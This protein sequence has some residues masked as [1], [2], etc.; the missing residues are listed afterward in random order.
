MIIY[1]LGDGICFPN[2]L[3]IEFD[4]EQTNMTLDTR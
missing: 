4:E 3:Y 1:V 2:D